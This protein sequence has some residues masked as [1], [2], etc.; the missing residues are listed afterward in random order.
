MHILC[1]ATVKDEWDRNALTRRLARRMLQFSVVNDTIYL[2]ETNA[3]QAYYDRVISAFNDVK[4]D[5]F[6]ITVI[7]D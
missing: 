5:T 2:E 7:P 1:R 4:T 6:G 3:G